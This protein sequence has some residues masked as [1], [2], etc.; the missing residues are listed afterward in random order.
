MQFQ[1]TIRND[2]QLLKVYLVSALGGI[3]LYCAQR[4][5]MNWKGQET[6]RD[7]VVGAYAI[8]VVIIPCPLHHSI[9]VTAEK[10]CYRYT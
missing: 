7:F 5:E 3:A 6:P 2:L 1:Q 9:I 4:E 10:K 8:V